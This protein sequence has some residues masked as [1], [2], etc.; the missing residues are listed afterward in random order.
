MSESQENPSARSDSSA[1]PKLAPQPSRKA[2]HRKTLKFVVVFMVSVLIMLVGY[3][4]EKQSLPNDWYLLQVAR[5]TGWLLRFVGYSCTVGGAERFKGKEALVRASLAAWHRGEDAP[6]LPPPG[7]DTVPLSPWEAWG[8]Q[9]AQARH[10]RV[11]VQ[12][13]L[14]AA[15]KDTTKPEPERS[16]RIDELQAHAM[17]MK[18]MDMGPL[19]SFVW[20]AGPDR[21]LADARKELE[22]TQGASALPEPER[23]RRVTELKA[24][25]AALEKDVLAASAI[26][27]DKRERDDLIFPFIVVPD[28][29]AVQSMAIFLAAILAFPAPWWRRLA[30]LLIGIP[31]LF[32]VNAFRLS[33]LGVIGAWDAGGPRFKFAHEYVWQGIYIVFVV[34]L[35]MAWVEL[36]V[37]RRQP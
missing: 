14:D 28:C 33:F 35:W 7:V 25:I 19:V 32:W 29:G 23:S 5:S 12:A 21:R 13:E 11:K 24:R 26:P 10:D 4:V 2:V 17:Q 34:A 8:F 6:A 37:R 20:K 16:K 3:E 9:A 30:G 1:E 31:A 27:R 22:E 36:L 15:L 18:T